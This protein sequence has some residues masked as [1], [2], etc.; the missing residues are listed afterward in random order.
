[1]YARGKGFDK[2]ELEAV[3]WFRKAA[4][5]GNREAQY[6]LGMAYLRGRGIQKS[7]SLGYE[8]LKKAA[9]QGHAEAQ[10]EVAKR[11]T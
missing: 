9:A 4:E 3:S 10:K 2:D 8:W 11:K 5:S 1:M 7:D 6:G